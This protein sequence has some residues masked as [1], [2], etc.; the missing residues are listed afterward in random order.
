[1]DAFLDSVWEFIQSFLDRAVV[2]ID[3]MVSPFEILGP[4][5]VIFL[6]ALF[7]VTV[8]RIIKRFYVTKRYIELEKQFYH[9]KSVRQE[10][11]KYSDRKKGK[12]LAKNI[13]HAQL[14]KVYYDYFF[15]G[16]L[17]NFIT[18]VIPILLAAS[19][20]TTVYTPD[21]LLER[22][23]RKW[24]FSFFYGSSSQIN[25]SSFFWFIICLFLVFI[26]YAVLKTVFQKK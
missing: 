18:N 12:R 15:E 20:V 13:D 8:T 14:N 23:G 11:L 19:Y 24:L 25:V 4:S 5:T 10:A 3:T 2:V 1:M 22:F 9:W 7:T 6:L 16:L 17:K 26:L 21:T